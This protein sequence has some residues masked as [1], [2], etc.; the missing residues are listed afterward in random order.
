[1]REGK[2]VGPWEAWHLDGSANAQEAGIWWEDELLAPKRGRS[3][4][5]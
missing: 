3:F 1:M 5:A 2:Q 4:Q